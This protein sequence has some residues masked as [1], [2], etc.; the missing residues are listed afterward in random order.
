MSL[1]NDV[2]K[3][4]EDTASDGRRLV[5]QVVEM[6][7]AR[8]REHPQTAFTVLRTIQPVFVHGGMA[9]VTRF[10][11]VVEV[12]EHDAEFSVEKYTQ[13]M[14][15]I[16]GDFILGLDQGAEYERQSSLLRLAFRQSDVEAIGDIA[17]KAAHDC[18][19]ASREAGTID[20]VA[21]LTDRV[22]ARIVEQY[23]GAPGPDQDTLIAWSRS[24][25]THIFVDLE[26]DRILTEQSEQAASLIRPHLDVLVARRKKALA[27]GDP[28][29][30]DVL[31][32]LIRQQA[33]GE[34]AFN[35]VEIRS[36]LIGMLVGM[37]PTVSKASALA[38]DELLRRPKE[39][40]GARK[41]AR[42]GN[43]ELFARYVNEAMRFAPQAPGLIR[44]ATVDYP[45]ARGTRHE[46]M[47]PRGTVVIAATQS[48]MFDGDVVHHP[49]EFRLDRPMS[50]Y[51]HYG[52][53][54][55]ACYGRYVNALI[56]PIIVKAALMI[57]G[58]ERAPGDAGKLTIDGNWPTTMT[59][60]FPT[61]AT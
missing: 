54:L 44:V 32:R 60:R 41:A 42:S 5:G 13:P 55:H 45:I 29:P 49:H 52:D 20:I 17:D 33:L 12:L 57:E 7:Q 1:V 51:L 21:D 61:A 27:A 36:N 22:P 46:Q 40:A 16:T 30:D 58:A 53:G 6:L 59:L 37:I 2:V 31:T 18:I 47:I 26:H 50:S 34:Q 4:A 43:D 56:I 48:A 25:F 35:D 23:L 24:L 15:D 9:V 28:V 19:M 38:I 8:L 39:L 3:L 14:R 10:D 11:D